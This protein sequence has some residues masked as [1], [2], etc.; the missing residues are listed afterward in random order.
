MLGTLSTGG[1]TGELREISAMFQQKVLGKIEAQ[2]P[3]VIE[4]KKKII[5]EEINEQLNAIKSKK[6]IEGEIDE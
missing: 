5:I 3:V 1:L 4:Q 6:I 2:A